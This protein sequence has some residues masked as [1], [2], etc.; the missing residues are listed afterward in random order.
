MGVRESK[1]VIDTLTGAHSSAQAQ[2]KD[3][4][5]VDLNGEVRTATALDQHHLTAKQFLRCLQALWFE[6]P[7]QERSSIIE[8][9][10]KQKRSYRL[11]RSPSTIDHQ[12]LKQELAQWEAHIEI[13]PLLFFKSGYSQLDLSQ[14]APKEIDKY[15]RKLK[16]E[17]GL[18]AVRFR[19]LQ[20]VYHRCKESMGV[21][22]LRGADVK[23]IK[24]IFTDSALSATET[25][26]IPEWV[27]QGNRLQNLCLQVGADVSGENC[28]LANL[29]YY[30][31]VN[32][33]M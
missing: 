33:S 1:V 3:K 29:F 8:I 17:K 7:I 23:A 20:V 9:P 2:K 6:I 24:K 18:S 5:T 10:G 22:N 26:Y 14:D 30:D 21:K 25:E 19:L 28:H 15:M 31:E 12:H 4:I 32:A 27:D 11:P 16:D 13:D